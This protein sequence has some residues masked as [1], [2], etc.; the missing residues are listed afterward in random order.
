MNKAHF[1]VFNALA[2][3]II[4]LKEGDSCIY[5][6]LLMYSSGRQ[7]T[8]RGQFGSPVPLDKVKDGVEEQAVVSR[9]NDLHFLRPQRLILWT[10]LPLNLEI[11]VC[12]LAS[13]RSQPI[14][15]AS[16]PFLVLSFLFYFS[17]KRS[18][19]RLVETFEY[20]SICRVWVWVIE[21]HCFPVFEA[22]KT[23]ILDDRSID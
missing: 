3:A 17:N 20:W 22:Y 18:F 13:H 7:A 19:L 15:L 21:P 4:L 1:E 16:D 11:S 10:T 8:A 2:S 23:Q 6:W 5:L 14:S 12:S 9:F